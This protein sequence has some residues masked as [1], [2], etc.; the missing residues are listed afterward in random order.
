[1]RSRLGEHRPCRPIRFPSR[2]PY[3]VSVPISPNH[4]NVGV[5][6]CYSGASWKQRS[7]KQLHARP[8]VGASHHT[9]IV[10]TA[11]SV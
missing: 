7:C 2:P 1:M 11:P 6:Q 8:V 4:R 9:N 10:E 3:H 5:H